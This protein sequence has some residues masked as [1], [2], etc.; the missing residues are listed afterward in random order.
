MIGIFSDYSYCFYIL[1]VYRVLAKSLGW[2]YSLRH[3]YDNLNL[4]SFSIELERTQIS[5][6]DSSKNFKTLGLFIYKLHVKN[7]K[8]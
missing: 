8:H 5:A 4:H 2:L 7:I 6:G 1:P 3:Q